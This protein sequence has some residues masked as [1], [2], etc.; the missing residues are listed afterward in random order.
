MEIAADLNKDALQT[1]R[2]MSDSN[3]MAREVRMAELALTTGD[4]NFHDLFGGRNSPVQGIRV[5]PHDDDGEGT[6]VLISGEAGTGKT[7]LACQLAVA[8]LQFNRTLVVDKRAR[9]EAAW[10]RQA[11]ALIYTLDQRAEELRTLITSGLWGSK[12]IAVLKPTMRVPESLGAAGTSVLMSNSEVLIKKLP[13]DATLTHIE[14]EL[15]CDLELNLKGD[16]PPMT[17]QE[18]LVKIVVIDAVNSVLKST[19][20]KYLECFRKLVGLVGQARENRGFS[21]ILTLEAEHG[22]YMAEEFIPQCVLSLTRSKDGLARRMIE[23]KKA[24]HQPHYVGVHEFRIDEKHGVRVFPSVPARAQQ[25]EATALALAAEEPQAQKGITFGVKEIDDYLK[26]QQREIRGGSTTLLWGNPG[27][28]KT[29]LG[30]RF[31]ATELAGSPPTGVLLLTSKIAP[32]HFRSSLRDHVAKLKHPENGPDL[33]DSVD[34][35][36]I[37]DARDPFKTTSMIC[38]DVIDALE[39]SKSKSPVRRALVFGLGLLEEAPATRDEQWRFVSVLVRLFESYGVSTLLV[40]WPIEGSSATA[41][42]PRASKLCGNELNAVGAA[43]LE[44]PLP[45]VTI[46][47]VERVGYQS[48]P[49]NTYRL[50]VQL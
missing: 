46:V 8:S 26:E 21:L 1:N 5:N 25:V 33:Q 30:I 34:R 49:L 22:T 35:L 40:D 31:L 7:T 43:G 14:R 42:R 44:D 45:G 18:S 20:N 47:L 2:L 38:A 29:E 10:P 41:Q 19:E 36:Q 11:R 48:L 39:G 28:G 17:P 15:E 9:P 23:V 13:V 4:A 27:S 24:R 37:I 50:Q 12:R 32:D 3:L 16:E 6:S